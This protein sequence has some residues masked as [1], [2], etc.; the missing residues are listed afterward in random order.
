MGD[1]KQFS[2]TEEESGK[3][4]DVFLTNKLQCN[5]SLI[6]KAIHDKLITVNGTVRKPHY[7]LKP[8]DNIQAAV[9]QKKT[10]FVLQ[11]TPMALDILHED[12]DIIV[13]NKPAGIC[14]HPGAGREKQT[15]VSGL[16]H[17][18]SE[19]SQLPAPDRPGIVHRLDR[20]TTG[21][22]LIA[23]TDQAYLHL[24]KQFQQR[25]VDKSYI[26]I[27]H[28]KLKKLFMAIDLPIRRHPVMRKKMTVSKTGHGRASLTEVI[29]KK[30]AASVSLIEVKLKTGR[31]HQIRVHLSAVG[32][33]VVGD[34]V[35]SRGQKLTCTAICPA[36]QMLH[37][38]KLGIKHP[39]NSNEMFFE[40]P[41]PE[42]IKSI[43]IELNLL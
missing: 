38:W 30:A 9:P 2:I 39:K 31:T 4:I 23:K 37:A 24:K 27:V 21:C 25:T 34:K 29:R 35:Y 32:H 10:E 7:I 17:Y 6:Q 15:I 36:R 40:A 13:L 33:P 20:D 14:V 42:D 11:P 3:R 22:L 5:R 41:W 28:G 1:M 12:E 26:A 19:L 8:H 18:T 43:I 16:M